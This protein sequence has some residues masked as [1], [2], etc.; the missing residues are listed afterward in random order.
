MT[1]DRLT[2]R[3]V[4]KGLGAAGLLGLAGCVSTGGDGD[5]GGNTTTGGGN[6]GNGTGNGTTQ[7]TSINSDISVG[8]VYTSAGLGDEGFNDSAQDGMQDAQEYLGIDVTSIEPDGSDQYLPSLNRLAGGHE[9]VCGL[10]FEMATAMQNA[11]E[12][13]PDQQFTIV[14]TSVDADNVA[15]YLFREQEGSYLVGK[16]AAMLATMDFSAGG[17]STNPDT[18]QV[19]FIGGKRNP[20]IERFHA[21]FKAGAEENGAEV[22]ANYAGSWSDIPQGKSIAENQYNSGADVIFP[23]AGSTGIGAFQAAQE[24]ERFVFGVDKRQSVSAEDYADVILGSMVKR[25]GEAFYTSIE[26]V[27]ADE[28]NGGTSQRLGLEAGGVELAYGQQLGGEIPADVKSGIDEAR[29]GIIDG[30]IT[31]PEQP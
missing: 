20:V 5:G 21:G 1:S 24:M 8:M 9:L 25:V 22:L 16:M 29:Q 13:N 26:N 6:G 12:Q 18:T 2:R 17:G 28:F 19:G 31:V 30:D 11:A 23:A 3:D 14:D 10:S 15:S 27:I 4:A 7:R